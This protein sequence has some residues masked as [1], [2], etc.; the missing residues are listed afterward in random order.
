M[1]DCIKAPHRKDAD[2]ALRCGS[3]N[4]HS[5][6][7]CRSIPAPPARTDQWLQQSALTDTTRIQLIH[8]DPEALESLR[9]HLQEHTS[10]AVK[11]AGYRDILRL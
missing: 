7:G 3:Q 5:G 2:H 6:S 8:G 10:F 11:V 9:V 1:L 4:G